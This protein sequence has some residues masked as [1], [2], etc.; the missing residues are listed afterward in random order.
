M[1]EIEGKRGKA[2]CYAINIEDECVEQIRAM[3]DM[4]F[5]EGANTAIMPDAHFGIGCT[6]SSAG[7]QNFAFIVWQDRKQTMSKRC[8]HALLQNKSF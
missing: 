4:P 5:A 7:V 2:A 3:L 8:E 1:F 6:I